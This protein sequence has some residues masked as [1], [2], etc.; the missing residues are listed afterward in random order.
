[1]YK[2]KVDVL[3][4]D[5][6][7]LRGFAMRNYKFKYTTQKKFNLRLRYPTLWKIYGKFISQKVYVKEVSCVVVTAYIYH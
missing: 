6:K 5:F 3:G 7:N 4:T 1:M 2:L